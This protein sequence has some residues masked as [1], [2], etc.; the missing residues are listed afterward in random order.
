MIPEISTVL[1]ITVIC[2][3]VGLGVKISPLDDK[4]IPL[5]VG[6]VGGALGALGMS[7]IP[8]YPA[9][10]LI[11]AVAVGIASGLAATG[12]DQLAK[13]LKAPVFESDTYTGKHEEP[14]NYKNEQPEDEEHF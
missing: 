1:G 2:Y 8:D 11:D 3:L 5:I 4:F 10:N 7:M 6:V 13:Q 9:G 12:M 14:D